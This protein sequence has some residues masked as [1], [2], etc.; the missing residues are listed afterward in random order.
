[1]NFE[2]KTIF[3]H[4]DD[5]WDLE[6]FGAAMVGRFNKDLYESVVAGLS[7]NLTVNYA[8]KRLTFTSSLNE[9]LMR[10]TD[11]FDLLRKAYLELAAMVKEFH[12]LRKHLD[13]VE[14]AH[15][16]V[17]EWDYRNH[18]EFCRETIRNAWHNTKYTVAFRE[19]KRLGIGA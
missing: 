6:I 10:P 5:V 14:A 2:T 1:M 8:G 15:D 12:N 9:N 7:M 16:A 11:V 18:A 3:R 4:R 19:A 17:M 13:V